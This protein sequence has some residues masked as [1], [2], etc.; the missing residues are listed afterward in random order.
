MFEEVLFIE[1]YTNLIYWYYGVRGVR[2]TLLCRRT[3]TV[4]L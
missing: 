2:T 1:R 4:Y 3:V